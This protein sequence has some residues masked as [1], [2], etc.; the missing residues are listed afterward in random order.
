M[1]LHEHQPPVGALAY[2]RGPIA[3]RIGLM[4]PSSGE[5]LNGVSGGRLAPQSAAAEL[6][7]DD[8]PSAVQPLA[9]AR[10]PGGVAALDER[11][12]ERRAGER[13]LD[14]RSSSSIAS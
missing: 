7:L 14:V 1:E 8:Q 12:P 6:V 2:A 11:R 4:N 5:V 13:R 10:D 9:Q 3:A